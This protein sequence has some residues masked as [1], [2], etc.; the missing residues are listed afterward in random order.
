MNTK[1]AAI[2]AQYMHVSLSLRL[3]KAVCPN[4]QTYEGH[5]NLPFHRLLEDIARGAPE[6]VG[7]SV[8]IWNADLIWRLCRALKAALPGVLIFAGGPEVAFT[9]EEAL[10]RHPE[11]D[12]VLSGEGEA[13]LPGFLAALEAGTDPANAPGVSRRGRSTPPPAPMPPS[14]W[15]DPW[16][17]G[18]S[19][20]ENR[21]LYVETS[22]GCPFACK[23]C[24][25]SLTGPVRAL[26]AKDAIARLTKLADAGARLIKLVDR[27][28]N[29][30][31][32]RACEIW[33]GLIEH[34]QRTQ[35]QITYHFEIG[36]HLLGERSFEIL[37]SAPVNLFQFEAGIQ[38]TEP[39]ALAA[40]GRGVPFSALEPPLKR[41]ANLPAVH[42]HVDLIAGLPGETFDSFARS[43]DDAFS[44][45]AQMLQLGF[46][47]LLPGCELRRDADRLG[48][49]YAPDPPYEVTQAP[50]LDFADL[51]RLKDVER[52]LEWYANSGKYPLTTRYLLAGKSPFAFFLALAGDF[53]ARGFFDR[54]LGEKERAAALLSAFDAPQTRCLMRHDLL[55]GGLRR[56]L[57]DA[58]SFN[59]N[60]EERRLLRQRYRPVR[61]QSLFNYEYDVLAYEAG[62]PLEKRATPVFYD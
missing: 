29:F 47:K 22:R 2:N 8:Y 58:L 35:P 38:T 12:Y 25:S 49:A 17:A 50:G 43:F 9:P 20:L 44:V 53:R 42:L 56:A 60:E 24:L 62:G 31:E 26:S 37:Q 39:G 36:A 45:G 52:V 27:T 19:G 41:I 48:I 32:A 21:I 30:D 15:P 1:I 57:P 51:C 40:S 33:R 34:A 10:T 59:E 16:K 11:A 3:L 5:I 14:V 18:V 23:Y 13:V 55:R 6:A 28:F 54:D 4:V 7:F 46:L 61:G